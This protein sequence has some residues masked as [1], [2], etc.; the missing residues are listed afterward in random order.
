MAGIVSMMSDAAVRI[1]KQK[2]VTTV[3][4][5]RPD[6]R[7]AVDSRTAADLADAFRAV[8][9]DEDTDACV[10]FGDH[11]TFCSEPFR[12]NGNCA[13]F[14]VERLEKSAI[15]AN[16][17]PCS[18]HLKSFQTSLGVRKHAAQLNFLSSLR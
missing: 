16:N 5:S 8:D 4:L 15:S 18:P 10:L 17:E 6:V 7:N 3:I 13:A 12:V 9:A 2:R 11:G 1:E 14:P